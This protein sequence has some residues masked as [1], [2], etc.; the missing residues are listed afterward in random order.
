MRTT[1]SRTW[2]NSRSKTSLWPWATYRS[3]SCTLGLDAALASVR[4]E[5]GAI[6]TN[7]ARRRSWRASIASRAGSV[8]AFGR[9][10]L[11]GRR[12]EQLESRGSRQGR[13]PGDERRYAERVVARPGQSVPLES[14]PQGECQRA[15]VWEEV[16]QGSNPSN[17]RGAKAIHPPIRSESWPA[18]RRPEPPSRAPSSARRRQARGLRRQNRATG[19]W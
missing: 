5:R 9:V 12:A 8:V 6:P 13:T 1:P 18:G 3:L 7:H 16:G 10:G 15:V 2:S 4:S 17:V 14:R 11:G 19:R